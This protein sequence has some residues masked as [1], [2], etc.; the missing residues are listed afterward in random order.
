VV[1]RSRSGREGFA[2]ASPLAQQLAKVQRHSA[3][4][5]EQPTKFTA[6]PATGRQQLAGASP[7]LAT[8]IE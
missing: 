1:D 4:G 7:L 8:G 3:T 2:A 6:L 5:K